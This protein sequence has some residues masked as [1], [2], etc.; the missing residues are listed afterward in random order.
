MYQG[1]LLGICS[2]INISPDMGFI[3]QYGVIPECQGQ[4]IGTVLWRRAIEHIGPDR[5][6]SL[7]TMDHMLDKYMTKCNFKFCSERRALRHTGKADCSQLIE[8]IDGISVVPITKH[9]IQKVI[10]YDKEICDGMDRTPLLQEISMIKEYVNGVALN[11]R[12]EV[13][14]YCV[15]KVTNLNTGAIEPLYANDE[16][17]AELLVRKCCQSLSITQTNGVVF[18]I[19]SANTKAEAIARKMGLEVARSAYKLFTKKVIEGSVDR[20]YSSSS[21][22]FYPF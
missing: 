21:R 16:K 20:I 22:W 17:I 1:R 12:E 8:A 7:I 13:V 19:W 15:V 18:S 10:Q 2:G 14:G 9:N 4:G 6:M 11:H 3:G 5:N